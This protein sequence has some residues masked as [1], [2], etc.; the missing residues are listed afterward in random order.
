MSHRKELRR[1]RQ[2]QLERKCEEFTSVII[3]SLDTGELDRFAEIFGAAVKE[4]L[5]DN[6][7]ETTHAQ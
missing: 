2:R 7:T 5:D 6:Q 3:G 1:Q 4:V